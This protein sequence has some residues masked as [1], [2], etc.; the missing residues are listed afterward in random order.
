M[1]Q[2]QHW[3]SAVTGKKGWLASRR[4]TGT[5]EGQLLRRRTRRHRHTT[6]R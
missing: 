1:F 6:C 4:H 2:N 3:Q 5:Q